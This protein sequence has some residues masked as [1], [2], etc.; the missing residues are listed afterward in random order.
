MKKLKEFIISFSGLKQGKHDFDFTIKNEFFESFEYDE[1]NGTDIN[2]DVTL[3]KMST[4]MELEMEA[5]GTV[6]VNCDLTDE[7]YDQEISADL[8][9]VVKFGDEFNNDNDEILV[10]PHREHQVD[11]SQYV[12]EMLVLSVP[13]KKV[14][15]GVLDG[16]LQSE[17][18]DKLEELHPKDIEENKEDED[19]DPRWDELKKLL[20]GK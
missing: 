5:R 1:F 7:A 9:L 12:Y 6:N 14:H 11:I 17:T 13:L 4:M 15:P 16:T 18:L 3:N 8:K 10:I 2:L 19:N 20:T